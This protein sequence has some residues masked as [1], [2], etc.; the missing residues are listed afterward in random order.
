MQFPGPHYTPPD[1]LAEDSGICMTFSLPSIDLI[2]I[3]LTSE[4]S[5]L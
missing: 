3:P 1:F 2:L 4:N 5:L